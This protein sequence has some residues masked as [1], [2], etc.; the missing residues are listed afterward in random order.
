MP[1]GVLF[2]AVGDAKAEV[3]RRVLA[4]AAPPALPRRRVRPAAGAVTWVLDRAAARLLEDQ[5]A[6]WAGTPLMR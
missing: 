6:A 4:E 1:A 2:L 5:E 3:A